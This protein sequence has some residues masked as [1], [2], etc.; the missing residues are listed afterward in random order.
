MPKKSN[1]RK[2]TGNMTRAETNIIGMITAA[3]I[4]GTITVANDKVI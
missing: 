4:S 1:T 3:M 2:N